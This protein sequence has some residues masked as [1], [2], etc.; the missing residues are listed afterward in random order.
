MFYPSKMPGYD[1]NP[2]A[3]SNNFRDSLIDEKFTDLVKEIA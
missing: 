1:S 2:A 3:S